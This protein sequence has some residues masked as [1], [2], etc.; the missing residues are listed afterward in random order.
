MAFECLHPSLAIRRQR[1]LLLVAVMAHTVSV[2]ID[3]AL[4][5]ITVE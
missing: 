5:H 1:G 4:V 3:A 2:N